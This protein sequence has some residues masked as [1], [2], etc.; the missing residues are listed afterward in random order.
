MTASQKE[1]VIQFSEIAGVDQDVAEG[2]LRKYK[3]SLE[4]SMDN[5]LNDPEKH[6]REFK[7]KSFSKPS[8]SFFSKYA[9]KFFWEKIGAND[10][11]DT[12]GLMKL[13]TDLGINIYDSVTIVFPYFCKMQ[14][15][16][17]TIY[18]IR[19]SSLEKNLL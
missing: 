4:V 19:K 2:T 14:N 3:W 15:P 5:Y 7:K 11:I 16:V 10:Y 13:Y 8:T 12:E 18:I 17:Y 1:L 6:N 9:G